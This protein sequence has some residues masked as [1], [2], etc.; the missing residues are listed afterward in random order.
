MAFE[1]RKKQLFRLCVGGSLAV[2]AFGGIQAAKG[3]ASGQRPNI[4]LIFTDDQGYE[5]VG[6][7]GAED[8]ETPNLDRMASNGVRFTD[9]Y[10]A[11]PVCSPSRAAL[12]TGSYPPRVSLT[13]V[14]FP[15]HDKGLNPD[16]ITTAE[17]LKRRGYATACFGKWHLGHKP[18]FLPTNQGFD[19]YFGIP[20]SN[21]MSVDPQMPVA[22][23][24]RFRKGMT[25]QK[26]REQDP[27]GG[28]VPLVR[29]EKVVE[30]PAKQST[31]TKR[32]TE[33]AIS[34][35]KRHQQEPFFVYLPHTMPHV[36]L[37]TSE[38]FEGVSDRGSYG[39]VIEEIDWS[40]G[41]IIQTLRELDLEKETLVFFTSDNGP[42]LSKGEAG[43]SADPLRS[44]KFTTWEGGMRM[45]AIAQWP[46]KIPK[47]TVC[48]EIAA[49]IDLLPTLGKIA[50]AALPGDRVIDGRDIRNLLFQ[51]ETAV[52]PHRYYHYYRGNNLRAI[53][54][55]EW[56][57]HLN[58]DGEP[59]LFNLAKDISEQ[60]DVAGEH[61][62][63]VDR[64]LKVRDRFDQ[65]LKGNKRPIGKIK[66]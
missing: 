59:Q 66:E 21:D 4:V 6:V 18:R 37:A 44:G 29:D 65:E 34:F 14:L 20:Y 7:Y 24:C 35:I 54:F 30:Y 63:L 8:F 16:E 36:P 23:E 27:K 31:L 42:W 53:R 64:L 52:S 22:D 56:K 26:M 45:P 32:Y 9:F 3:E 61:P 49:T 19:T 43:G 5:D 38:R 10:V 46:T 1:M 13:G 2:A 50:G 60:N 47:G 12:L 17:L 28:W 62:N 40:V 15:R 39:D 25:L 58:G 51:P 11:A 48:S 55:D 57:L 33:E 41:Q